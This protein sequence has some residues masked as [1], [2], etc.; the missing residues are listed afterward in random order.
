MKKTR[1]SCIGYALICAVLLCGCAD[2][3]PDLTEEEYQQVVHYAAGLLMKYQEDTSDR[4]T[5]LEPGYTPPQLL[6][7]E[8]M[9]EEAPAETPSAEP[10]QEEAPPATDTPPETTGEA[11]EEGTETPPEGGEE[12]PPQ[13]VPTEEPSASGEAPTESVESATG[14]APVGERIDTGSAVGVADSFF[15]QLAD[16]LYV[17]YEGYSIKNFYPD[18]EAQGAV[19][20]G[21]GEKLLILDFQIANTLDTPVTINTAMGGTTYKLIINDVVQ[22]FSLVT[23]IDN[24]LSSML[25][26]L[27]PGERRDVVIV[28]RVSADVARNID[29]IDL[30]VMHGNEIQIVKIE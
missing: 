12:A 16:G 5:Y 24:D 1:V 21:E 14:A 26:E 4:L 3:Y 27:A 9:A 2:P 17:A 20:A 15:Q 23:M 25:A 30:R 28:S 11:P 8:P 10:P 19:T 29:T 6:A 13:D 7:L 18:M 22:G